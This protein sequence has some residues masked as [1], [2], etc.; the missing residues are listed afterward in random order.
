MTVAESILR[1][2]HQ[3]QSRPSTSTGAHLI[4]PRCDPQLAKRG[5]QLTLCGPTFADRRL[6]ARIPDQGRSRRYLSA[7]RL[8]DL[9]GADVVPPSQFRGYFHAM[10]YRYG[11][12]APE[13][14]IFIKISASAQRPAP[15]L[16]SSSRPYR[17]GPIAARYCATPGRGEKSAVAE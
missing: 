8:V 9:R 17:R 14:D 13:R 5:G 4:R 2:V 15:L 10:V 7:K 6:R 16:R 11:S 3:S 1:A 12:G